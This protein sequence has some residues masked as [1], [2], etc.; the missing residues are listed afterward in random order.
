M[1][2]F[3]RYIWPWAEN[4]SLGHDSYYCQQYK[5][6]KPFPT[7]R[8]LGPNNYVAAVPAWNITAKPCHLYRLCHPNNPHP[9]SCT[10]S[11]NSTIN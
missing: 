3:V 8:Q 7:K 6:T 11:E 1:N 10:C 4:E 5:N 9:C 2:C